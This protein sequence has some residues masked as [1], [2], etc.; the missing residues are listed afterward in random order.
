MI[1]RT[2]WLSSIICC[3]LIPSMATATDYLD[4][5][6]FS[7]PTTDVA[8]NLSLRSLDTYLPHNDWITS[9]SMS[10]LPPGSLIV[11]FDG[12][13]GFMMS[14]LRSQCRQL[15]RRLRPTDY[16]ESDLSRNI[17][18]PT[19]NQSYDESGSTDAWWK[20]SWLDSMSYEDGGAPSRPYVHTYG[21]KTKY[22]FGPIEATNALKLKVDYIGLFE[23]DPDPV[24]PTDRPHR[25]HVAIDVQPDGRFVVG[26]SIE[27]NVKPKVRLGIPANHRLDSV[28]RGA[29]VQASF[30]VTW[31]GR[32]IV[33]GDVQLHWKGGKDYAA[34]VTMTILAW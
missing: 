6:S 13:H 17:D 14:Q 18:H 11:R 24:D 31:W 15:A 7:I 25:S 30:T 4:T 9:V 26:A 1:R 22:R 2:A 27:V 10:R 12:L 19:V 33:G 20:R 8:A 28:I 23:V 21:N 16:Y 5:E 34:T 32:A 3:L 29:T